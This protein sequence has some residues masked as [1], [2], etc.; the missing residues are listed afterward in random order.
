MIMQSLGAGRALL[1]LVAG[2]LL[3][4]ACDD[5][6]STN[7][8]CINS[9]GPDF[10]RAFNQDANDEPLDASELDLTLTPNAEP[11]DVPC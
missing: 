10:V 11:F 7:K 5:D 2:G 1:I 4:A 6:G 9:L 3:L 8:G